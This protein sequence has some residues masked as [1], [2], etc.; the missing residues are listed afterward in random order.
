MSEDPNKFRNKRGYI[1]TGNAE[2]QM[3]LNACHEQL[4][5]SKVGNLKEMTDICLNVCQCTM[6]MQCL[7]R[8]AKGQIPWNWAYE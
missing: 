6:C 7:R 5:I 4:I 2:T 3:I 8:P 1:A